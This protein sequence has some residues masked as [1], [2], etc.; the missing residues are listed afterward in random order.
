MFT[1]TGNVAEVLTLCIGLCFLDQEGLSVYPMSPLQI[2]WVNMVCMHI[3]HARTYTHTHTHTRFSI[4]ATPP[5]QMKTLT[6]Q[7]P[8]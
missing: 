3:T 4:T 7:C 6:H 1:H 2:L 8:R 5:T